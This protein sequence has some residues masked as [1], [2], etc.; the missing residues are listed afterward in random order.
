VPL[1]IVYKSLLNLPETI[2]PASAF[3]IHLDADQDAR[4]LPVAGDQ[5]RLL[6]RLS[7]VAGKVV[8]DL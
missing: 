7:E 1:T 8:L 4:W 2:G 6:L 3:A 5:D